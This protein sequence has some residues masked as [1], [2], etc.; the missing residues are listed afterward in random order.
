MLILVFSTN[1]KDGPAPAVLLHSFD[2]TRGSSYEA[3]P[4]RPGHFRN[5]IPIGEFFQRGFG[6][7]VVYQGDLASHNEVEFQKG[8]TRCSIEPVRVFRRAY[9]WGRDL[10]DCLGRL[11]G[12]GL[13]GNRQ[14]HRCQESGDHGHSKCGKAA[15]WTA[16]QD[17]RFALVIA[18]QSGHPGAAL[19][20]RNYGE[21]L[22]KMVT[23][24]SLLAVP[25]CRGISEQ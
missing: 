5:G 1:K 6:F 17:Q 8:I 21:T 22:E 12:Y 25:Q 24:L 4:D 11:T 3:H 20:R 7:V 14:R 13:S 19:S 10:R 16:A 2:N 9:E 15:L 18:A 23:P